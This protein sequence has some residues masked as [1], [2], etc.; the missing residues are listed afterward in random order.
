MLSAVL[1]PSSNWQPD[2]AGHNIEEM[3]DF[4]AFVLYRGRRKSCCC[5]TNSTRYPSY[6][7]KLFNTHLLI[8][9]YCADNATVSS[10]PTEINRSCFVCGS[11]DT[12]VPKFAIFTGV[13]LPHATPGCRWTIVPSRDS[14]LQAVYP[15]LSD[16]EVLQSLQIFEVYTWRKGLHSKAVQ[17]CH[18]WPDTYCTRCGVCWCRTAHA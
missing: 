1:E 17:T 8:F 14:Y 11:W 15:K 4:N 6:L 5:T 16:I 10:P 9:H 13:V 2:T 7:T 18:C 3:K 12:Y